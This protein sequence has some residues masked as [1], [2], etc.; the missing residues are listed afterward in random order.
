MTGVQ[1]ARGTASNE[2]HEDAARP[3]RSVR[4][5]TLIEIMVAIVLF[6]FV[7]L[8]TGGLVTTLAGS[9]TLSRTRTNMAF[10]MQRQVETFHE[11]PYT[12]LA[13]GTADTTVAN[14]TVIRAEWTVTQV[15]QGRLAQIDLTLKQIPAGPGGREQAARLFIANRD[16]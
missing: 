14:G 4:G 3:V 10:H 2:P 15:V 16:P 8:S 11:I 9:G 12:S 13:N 7:L 1:A 5:F 6:S